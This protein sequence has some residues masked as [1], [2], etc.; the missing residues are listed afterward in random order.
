M[1]A[2]FTRP[3][4]PFLEP[5]R[6]VVFSRDLSMGDS[7][8]ALPPDLSPSAFLRLF[9]NRRLHARHEID[10]QGNNE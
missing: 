9:L 1:H 6:L 2:C 7:F 3:V 8:C 4:E 5:F 10:Q